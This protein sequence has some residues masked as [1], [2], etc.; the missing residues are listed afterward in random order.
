MHTVLPILS[1]HLINL[2][3]LFIIFFFF[4]FL[5]FHQRPSGSGNIPIGVNEEGVKRRKEKRRLKRAEAEG[6]EKQSRRLTNSHTR[7][8]NQEQEHH[9]G[10]AAYFYF[11]FHAIVYFPFSIFHFPFSIL[12]IISLYP[13]IV[14]PLFLHLLFVLSAYSM[15]H[16]GNGKWDKHTCWRF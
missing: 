7:G 4:F 14:C 12:C 8:I 10:L 2:F 13:R 11:V 1:R 16:R 9:D 3:R 6:R 15:Q 5:L